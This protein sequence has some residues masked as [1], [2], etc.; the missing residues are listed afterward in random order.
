MRGLQLPEVSEVPRYLV[1][2]HTRGTLIS[3][4]L[5]KPIPEIPKVTGYLGMAIL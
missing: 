4:Y 5:G 2:D 1:K 3:G